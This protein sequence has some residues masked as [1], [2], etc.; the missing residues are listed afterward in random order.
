M[1]RQDSLQNLTNGQAKCRQICHTWILWER[2][3]LFQSTITNQTT[4]GNTAMAISL[5]P[6]HESLDRGLPV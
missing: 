3:G 5:D 2:A 6:I 1:G 4:I